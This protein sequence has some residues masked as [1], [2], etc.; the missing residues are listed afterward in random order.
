MTP[1]VTF[2]NP[3]LKARVARAKARQRFA[4][5]RKAENDFAMRLKQVAR[6]I[7]EII[8]GFDPDGTLEEFFHLRN[9]LQK[10]GELLRPWAW[11]VSSRMIAEVARRDVD[12]WAAQGKEMGRALQK[13]I[14]NA[15]TGEAMRSMMNAQVDLITSLPHGAAERVHKLTMEGINNGLRADE[16]AA[17]ILRTGK[18]TR[19]RAMTIARTETTRTATALTAAR[20]TYVGSTHFIWTTAGD[21][22]VRLRHKKLEG[23]A[24]EWENPPVAGENGEVALPGAIYNCRCVAMPIIP[25]L[26]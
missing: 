6:T 5:A 7:G 19:S 12:A 9:A 10:Y 1:T 13:E 3:A 11:K 14:A 8:K 16:V 17:E 20:A 18:V 26:I 23:K 2:E 24:F 4:N 25:D 21:S 15:P 22:N